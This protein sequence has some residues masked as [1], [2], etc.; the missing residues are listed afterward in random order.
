MIDK[1]TSIF[2][3]VFF[4]VALLLLLFGV[5]DRVLGLFGWTL[6]WYHEP[7]RVLEFS[8]IMMTF[9]IGLLLRQIREELRKQKTT[10]E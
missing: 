9:V 10:S 3:R 4:A 1:L 2:S 5:L 7:G 8:G 6:A